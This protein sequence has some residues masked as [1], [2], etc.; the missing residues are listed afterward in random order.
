M[1]LLRHAQSLFNVAFAV[2]R[3]DPGIED[4]HLT[5]L[6]LNQARQAAQTLQS[7]KIRRIVTSP[8]TRAIQ[9]THIVN[10]SLGVPVTIDPVVGERA[11]FVCDIGTESD[12]LAAQWPQ[13]DFA[14][15]PKR[16]WVHQET[17]G[18]LLGRCHRFRA[19]MRAVP[20]W[21]DVLIVTHWG[22]IRGLTGVTVGNSETIHFDPTADP[23]TDPFA[24]VPTPPGLNKT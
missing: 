8:Y 18:E 24:G 5:D 6:G 4:P 2:T 21:P 16:W 20:D 1:I 11:A 3:V 17:E 10:K 7:R 9:T 19:A 15:L 13:Y 12:E 14:H 22:F 23:I